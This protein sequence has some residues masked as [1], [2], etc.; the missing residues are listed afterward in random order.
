MDYCHI[1]TS[2]QA[3]YYSIKLWIAKRNK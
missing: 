2:C 3:T 1:V